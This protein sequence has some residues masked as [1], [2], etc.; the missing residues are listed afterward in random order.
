MT[1]TMLFLTIF[2]FVAVVLIIVGLLN[3]KKLIAFEDRIGTALG[4]AIGKQLR[5]I[6]IRKN[7]KAK[8]HL[9]AVPCRKEVTTASPYDFMNIA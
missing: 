6:I 9:K 7:A 4:T 3:E 8:K 1:G 5:K 2:E